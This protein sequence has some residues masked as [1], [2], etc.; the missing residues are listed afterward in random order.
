MASLASRFV[1]DSQTLPEHIENRLSA[2]P[3]A[4]LCIITSPEKRA[5]VVE[6]HYS[7]IPSRYLIK[8]SPAS[9]SEP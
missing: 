1:A 4:Y 2:L 3:V 7:R 6:C 5:G 9:S 8:A